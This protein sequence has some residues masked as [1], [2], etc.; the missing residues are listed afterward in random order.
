L[1]LAA[2]LAGGNHGVVR[3]DVRREAFDLSSSQ[4][5]EEC[6]GVLPLAGPPA[7]RDH[8]VVGDEVRVAEGFLQVV[9][10]REGLSP[11]SA[12]LART[13]G[14]PEG[15]E[16]LLD[17]GGPRR[18]EDGEG[19]LG[20][21]EPPALPHGRRDDEGIHVQRVGLH[22][23]R[24]LANIPR[25]L[26]LLDELAARVGSPTAHREGLG[27]LTRLRETQ[28]HRHEH[29]GPHLRGEP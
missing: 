16:I 27:D 18:L 24:H 17:A 2:L 21:P 23:L 25:S 10:E 9:E 5:V 1:P 7:G 14:G 6:E 22:E 29:Q 20:P 8:R 12:L 4:V 19:V 28:R 13:E 26:Q 3:D 11:L 15:V